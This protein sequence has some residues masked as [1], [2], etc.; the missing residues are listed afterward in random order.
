[1][2]FIFIVHALVFCLHVY[3]MYAIMSVLNPLKLELLK[4]VSCHLG[5]ENLTRVL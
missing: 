2:T 3:S 1:M 5:A 4:V